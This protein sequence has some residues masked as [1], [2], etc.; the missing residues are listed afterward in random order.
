LSIIQAISNAFAILGDSEKRQN[1]DRFGTVSDSPRAQN[2]FRGFAHGQ[3][4]QEVSPEELFRMFMGNDFP[5][6]Q[7]QRG[8][9]HFRT[10]RQPQQAEREGVS[11]ILQLLPIVLMMLLSLFSMFGGDEQDQFSFQKTRTFSTPRKTS[12]KKVEFYVNDAYFNRNFRTVVGLSRLEKSV[13]NEVIS[14]DIVF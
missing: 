10:N 2:N 1:F 9:F 13:E 3:Q 12:R 14:N 4:F 11:R 8:G 5:G 6:F 7:T